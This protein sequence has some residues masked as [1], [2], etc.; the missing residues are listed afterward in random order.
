MT[1]YD[2]RALDFENVWVTA[3]THFGHENIR[4]YCKRPWPC[5]DTMDRG[6]LDNIN[7]LVGEADLLV[8]VG[9]LTMRGPTREQYVTRI[10]EQLPTNRIIVY[11]NHDRFKPS[12]Y[13][14]RGFLLAAT[15]LVLPGGVLI[16]HRP[17]DAEHWPKSRPVICGHVHN[18][19][20][21]KGNI[22]NAG[23]DIW[24]YKPILLNDALAQ[25]EL[26]GA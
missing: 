25:C 8:I 5:A 19:F 11:G 20:K 7:A 24:D 10:V 18:R 2:Y 26:E 23:V 17:T 16:V 9:D 15:S 1:T 14:R 22:V 12:W 6:I 13:L 3:D 21:T 4:T